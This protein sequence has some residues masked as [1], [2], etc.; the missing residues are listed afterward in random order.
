MA[1]RPRSKASAPVQ[2][3]PA[4]RA[5]A[6]PAPVQPTPAE[7]EYINIDEVSGSSDDDEDEDAPLA[8]AR[9]TPAGGANAPGG[10]TTHVAPIIKPVAKSNRALDIDL[11]FDRGKGKPSVCKF[12]KYVL[13]FNA[14]I[15]PILININR[16]AHERDPG[17]FPANIRW[18]Y[19]PTTGTTGLR[20]HIKNVHLE[21]YK[22]LCADHNIQP[23][24]NIV[25][26]QTSDEVAV[27]PATREPFNKDTLLRYIRDFVI[28]NDQVSLKSDSIFFTE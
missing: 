13:L 6:Q 28:A 16:E 23:S 25:E 8:K 11:L 12:C 26:K 20:K 18:S 1:P 3:A 5:P 19:E 4:Q 27:L 10:E 17:N 15:N 14:T 2:P 7:E 22:K 21:L 9:A 24:P